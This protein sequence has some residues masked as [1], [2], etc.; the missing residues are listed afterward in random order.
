[1][2]I[3]TYRASE[4]DGGRDGDGNRACAA[5]RKRNDPRHVCLLVLDP[6]DPQ[7][8]MIV[9]NTQWWMAPGKNTAGG[10]LDVNGRHLLG[11]YGTT[12]LT[13]RRISD[14]PIG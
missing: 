7:E 8:F 5:V 10:T 1:M 2:T 6:N 4:S 14:G 9:A 13:R 12:F 11:R 3:Y